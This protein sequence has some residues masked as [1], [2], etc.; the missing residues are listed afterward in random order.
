MDVDSIVDPLTQIR[1]EMSFMRLAYEEKIQDLEKRV[2]ELEAERDSSTQVSDVSV[3]QAMEL[4]SE[5]IARV[6]SD[7]E[8]HKASN[9]FEYS[10]YFRSGFGVDGNGQTHGV[11]QG[12][13]CSVKISSWQ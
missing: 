6:E 12:S 10:G 4:N 3:T 2:M 5:R 13:Q 7:L 1:S 11:F 8:K 9:G